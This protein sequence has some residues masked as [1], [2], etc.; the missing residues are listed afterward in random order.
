MAAPFFLIIISTDF[1]YMAELS[2][3]LLQNKNKRHLLQANTDNAYSL[4]HIHSIIPKSLTDSPVPRSFHLSRY[5]PDHKTGG[6]PWKRCVS[7]HH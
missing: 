7:R 6:L 4:S 5:A 1:N 3:S 2:E